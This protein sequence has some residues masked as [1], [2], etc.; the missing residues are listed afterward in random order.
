MQ[1]AEIFQSIDGEVNF[2]GQGR[3]TTFIRVAGCNLKCSYCD[4]PQ[5]H[6]PGFFM[7]VDQVFQKVKELKCPKVTITGGE[8]LFQYDETLK[9]VD[10]LWGENFKISV[11]SNGSF[12]PP[13]SFLSRAEI[14]WVFDYKIEFGALMQ[15]NMMCQLSSGHWVKIV[16]GS[17]QDYID[18]KQIVEKLIAQGCRAKIAFSPMMGNPEF[19]PSDLVKWMIEDRLWSV[20]LNVQIHKFLKV[21]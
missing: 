10:L 1:I 3:L 18:A 4:T 16:I 20:V 6:L 15:W 7:D 13:T 19:E 14:C 5:G 9:L 21:R 12:A 8:P 2:F 11:E 17:K